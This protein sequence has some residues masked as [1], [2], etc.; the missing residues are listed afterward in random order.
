MKHQRYLGAVALVCFLAVLIGCAGSDRFQR[1]MS[2]RQLF[3]EGLA[4][5]ALSEY[6]SA[7]DR[8]NKI[9]QEYD[10]AKS[11]ANRAHL[12]MAR[13]YRNNLNQP[14]EAIEHYRAFLERSDGPLMTGVRLE[15]ARLFR[16]QGNYTEAA[17]IYRTIIDQASSDQ[18]VEEGYYYL[19]EVY[20]DAEE[21]QK[22]IDTFQT[23]LDRFSNGDLA[24]GALFNLGEAY[25]QLDRTEEQFSV[26][27]RLLN[28]YPES[29]LREFTYLKAFRLA[30]ELERKPKALELARGYR[31]EYDQGQYWE[32]I[33]TLLR[34][35]FGV[36][37]STLSNDNKNV[38]AGSSQES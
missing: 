32:S 15:L 33:S 38:E 11:W 19:G 16:D 12:R 24:D 4:Y 6:S 10:R 14:D 36:D 28:S 2:A 18:T 31:N 3:S 1:R 22:S 35:E 21:Y 34:D 9:T 23:F 17:R 30:V 26:Y 13:I 5:E 29:G 27:S 37:P 8:Y 7:L 20:L 25:G